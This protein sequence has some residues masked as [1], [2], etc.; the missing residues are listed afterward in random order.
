MKAK[1]VELRVCVNKLLEIKSGLGL[2]CS[3]VLLILKITFL[4]K[5]NRCVWIWKYRKPG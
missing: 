5:L 1:K 3:I 2:L 4:P